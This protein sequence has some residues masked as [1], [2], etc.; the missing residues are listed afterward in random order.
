[1]ADKIG[2]LGEQSGLTI[3]TQT[4]Y[5]VPT[6]KAAKGKLFFRLTGGVNSA[7]DILVNG[8]IVASSGAMT[9]GHFWFSIATDNIL[10]AAPGAA[11]PNGQTAALTV[12]PSGTTYFLSAG[13]LV[14][15]TVATAALLAA[16]VQFVGV[17][18]D[19]A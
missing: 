4:V 9:S 6:G 18:T 14:Q 8:V 11:A 7:I 5:T 13:D 10:N 1:M 19:A 15:Y 3:G 16:N 17:E 2:V 12:A